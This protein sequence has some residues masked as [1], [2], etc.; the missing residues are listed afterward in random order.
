MHAYIFSKYLIIYPEKANNKN[1]QEILFKK[2]IIFDNIKCKTHN[3]IISTRRIHDRSNNFSPH[4][5][6]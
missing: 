4:H 3:I 5:G 1:V 6:F 2:H